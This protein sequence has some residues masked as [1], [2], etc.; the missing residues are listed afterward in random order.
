MLAEPLGGAHIRFERAGIS[1]D[2]YNDPRAEIQ[3]VVGPLSVRD[4]RLDLD[5]IVIAS[6]WEAVRRKPWA[7]GGVFSSGETPVSSVIA[8]AAQTV[9]E[10]LGP[11]LV[12]D[13]SVYESVLNRR[14]R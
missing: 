8:A 2:I 10:Y 6:D 1:L 11:F 13:M 12:G 9:S 3:V 7:T 4:M 14:R 5:E